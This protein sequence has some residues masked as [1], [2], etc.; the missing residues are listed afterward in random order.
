MK[1]IFTQADNEFMIQNYQ[2]MSY[3]EIADRLG[4]SERQIRGRLNNMG[5][6]KIGNRF[7]DEYFDNVD[8]PEK[9]YFLGLFYADGYV[10]HRPDTRNYEA[11]IELHVDDKDTLLAYQSAIEMGCPLTNRERDTD[12]NGHQYHSSTLVTRVYSKHFCERLIELGIV[13]NK[14]YR[15]EFPSQFSSP[16]AFVR[17]FLDG[18]GC[19]YCSGTRSSVSFT[20]P[21]ESFLRFLMNLIESNTGVI[22]HIYRENEWKVRLM[23]Y[24]LSDVLLLLN[25]IYN[26][27]SAWR[28]DRKYQ[29]YQAILGLAA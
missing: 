16:S 19:I 17:G 3:R 28:M 9:S 27:D 15:A 25:W 8:T 7:N 4:F 24:G 11:S 21:N 18:D 5:Y 22:G 26:S 2:T 10:V 13:P 6:K 1:S 12:F 29:K 20:N 14:T 23:Y